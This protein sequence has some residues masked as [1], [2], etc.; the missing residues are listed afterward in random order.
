MVICLAFS[1]AMVYCCLFART[2][3][4]EG[5]TLVGRSNPMCIAQAV[6]CYYFI[7]S[8]FFW[9]TAKSHSVMVKFRS[10]ST[11]DARL[12]KTFA[13]YSG[14]CFGIPLVMAMAVVSIDRIAFSKEN[15][16]FQAGI[17]IGYTEFN[18]GHQHFK[19]ADFPT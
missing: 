7:L 17:E 3:I 5:T 11:I 18:L 16:F 10:T 15:R 12:S 8:S 9:I 6:I 1:H 19:T 13:I 4:G 14:I 2:F